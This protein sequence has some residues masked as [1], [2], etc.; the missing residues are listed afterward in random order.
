MIVWVLVGLFLVVFLKLAYENRGASAVKSDIVCPNQ[1]D[2]DY[3]DEG[4]VEPELLEAISSAENADE[5]MD[6]ASEMND[7]DRCF[8]HEENDA[9]LQKVLTFKNDLDEDDWDLI[10]DVAEEGS[11]LEQVASEQLNS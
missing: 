2:D 11:T 8:F 4:E 7:D 10:Y 9:F 1:E 3:N 5:L 6:V